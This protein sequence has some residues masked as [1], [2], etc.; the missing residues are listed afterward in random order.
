MATNSVYEPYNHSEIEY[1]WHN[2]WKENSDIAEKK[3][4]D[5]WHELSLQGPQ[6]YFLLSNNYSDFMTMDYGTDALRLCEMF[7]GR[8]E[9]DMKIDDGGIDGIDRYLQRI[10][11]LVNEFNL[12]SAVGNAEQKTLSNKDIE[13]CLNLKESIITKTHG[14]IAKGRYHSLIAEYMDINNNLLKLNHG[15]KL[16]KDLLNTYLLL[17]FPVAP[18]IAAELFSIINGEDKDIMDCTDII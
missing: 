15:N 14:Q 13:D 6:P 10:W 11:R 3:Y 2:I 16:S 18:C 9:P 12:K 17:V 4:L 7:T 8:H 1:K 5:I